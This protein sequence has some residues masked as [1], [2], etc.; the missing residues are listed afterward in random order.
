MMLD[1]FDQVEC[2][3]FLQGDGFRPFGEVIVIAKM[4]QCPL[5][6]EGLMGPMTFIPHILNG[7]EEDVG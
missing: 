6:V 4:N 1:E 2:L 5:D 7:H 3:Y